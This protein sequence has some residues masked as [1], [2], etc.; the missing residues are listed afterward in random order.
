MV[1]RRIPLT[2]LTVVLDASPYHTPISVSSVNLYRIVDLDL[3][4]STCRAISLDSRKR[5]G[6]RGFTANV[7]TDTD[8]WQPAQ[9][10]GIVGL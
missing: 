9:E 2:G 4:E 8:Y 1:D 5:E 6:L 3:W 10:G 7:E